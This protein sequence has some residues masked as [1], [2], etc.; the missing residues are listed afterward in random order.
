MA[1]DAWA[2]AINVL[3]AEAGAEVAAA[4]GLDILM[5]VRTDEG[6]TPI[7]TGIFASP[8]IP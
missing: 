6:F 2:T 3:G 5:L 4:E 8:E 1:A 7:R